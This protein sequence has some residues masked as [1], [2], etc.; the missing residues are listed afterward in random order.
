MSRADVQAS[1]ASMTA[2]AVMEL[3]PSMMCEALAAKSSVAN[4]NQGT[5]GLL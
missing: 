5:A 1:K 2:T 4:N 3:L